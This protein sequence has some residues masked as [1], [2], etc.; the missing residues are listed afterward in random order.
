M[1]IKLKIDQEYDDGEKTFIVPKGSIG[2]VDTNPPAD[3][4]FITVFFDGIDGSYL[5]PY[6]EEAVEIINDQA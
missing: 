4:Y 1:K 5:V 2:T 3:P 6:T